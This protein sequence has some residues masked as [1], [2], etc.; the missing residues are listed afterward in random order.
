MDGIL[1]G[2]QKSRFDA[3]TRGR[4]WGWLSANDVRKLEN[5]APIEGGDA[6]LQ[7][8][9]MIDVNS[10]NDSQSNDIENE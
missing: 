3:Y 8:L 6:Y 5:M 4:N 10:S 7:P 1:R 9:N 2:D